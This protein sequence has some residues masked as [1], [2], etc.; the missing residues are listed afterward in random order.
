MAFAV[1]LMH[2]AVGGHC[3]S[4]AAQP[5][6]STPTAQSMQSTVQPGV[7][8]TSHH[9]ADQI[10]ATTQSGTIDKAGP[11]VDCVMDAA[12]TFVLP[13]AAM[14]AAV[15]V[16]VLLVGPLRSLAPRAIEPRVVVLGRPPPWAIP[17]HIQLQV[18]R[19]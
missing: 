6:Q 8:I 19:S 2:S 16:L 14:I 12:C 7:S 10:T 11:S 13:G 1:A 17:T 18:I 9:G 4:A 5:M 15:A 3:G